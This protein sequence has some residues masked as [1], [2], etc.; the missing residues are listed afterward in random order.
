MTMDTNISSHITLIDWMGATSLFSEFSEHPNLL[1]RDL[2]KGELTPSQ[3]VR[4]NDGPNLLNLNL[5]LS[6][7]SEQSGRFIVLLSRNFVTLY[8]V[9]LSYQEKNLMK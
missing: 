7:L 2:D 1:V 5:K 9:R 8:S 3:S 6:L 4:V